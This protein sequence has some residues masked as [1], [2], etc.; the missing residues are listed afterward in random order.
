VCE[1]TS[2]GDAAPVFC[3]YVFGHDA[4]S[5]GALWQVAAGCTSTRPLRLL[6][7]SDLMAKAMKEIS[8]TLIPVFGTAGFAG[9]LLRTA[10]G[11]RACDVRDKQIG[12]YPTAD[13]GATALLELA[14]DAA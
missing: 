12:V 9:H 11:F 8:T 10:R 3:Y 13:Q 1:C 7:D 14:T 2:Q 5:P 6:G 4:P